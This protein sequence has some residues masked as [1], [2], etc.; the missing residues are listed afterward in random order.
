MLRDWYQEKKGQAVTTKDFVD[1]LKQK[2]GEDLASFFQTWNALTALP[3][4]RDESTFTGSTV[5]VHLMKRATIPDG[6][7]IPLVVSGAG[8]QMETFLVDP[9][10]R[11]VL[12]VPFEVRRIDWDPDRTVLCRIR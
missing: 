7:K 8:G 5:K 6:L 1:F 2:T 9:K 4:F 11:P 10:T 12:E 3:S